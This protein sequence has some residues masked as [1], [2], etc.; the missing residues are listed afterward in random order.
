MIRMDVFQ[1]E[2]SQVMEDLTHPS[3]TDRPEHVR[4]AV[5]IFTDPL[6]ATTGTHAIV[7]CTEWDEFVVC[8]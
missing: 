1:V 6:S 2:P 3:V 5:K 7:L 8:I 4:K